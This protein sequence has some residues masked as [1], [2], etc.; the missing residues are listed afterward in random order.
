MAFKPSNAAKSLLFRFF[1]AAKRDSA[2]KNVFYHDAGTDY[3]PMGTPL[4]LFWRHMEMLRSGDTVCF[5][6]GFRGVWDCRERF[7]ASGIRPVVFLAAGLAGRPGYLEWDE[8]REL[9]DRY[10]FDFQCHTWSHQTLAGPWNGEIP[11]PEGGRTEEWFRR[12]LSDSK[13]EMEARL[14][15]KVTALCFPVGYYSESTLRRCRDSGYS[16]VYASWPGNAS[17]DFLQPRCLVQDLSAGAF[18]AVL[19]GGMNP[20]A[21]RYRA[22]HEVAE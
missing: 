3:T 22:M 9:Q 4:P 13:A 17:A 15:K 10:G 20:F 11:A 19:R 7:K 21:G 5:D 18:G 12:E 6:D 1:A 16:K 8:A 14:G 2:P